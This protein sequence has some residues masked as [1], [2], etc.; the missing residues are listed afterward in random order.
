MR[1]CAKA[2]NAD[3]VA[4]PYGGAK[5]RTAKSKM[6]LNSF[7]TAHLRN[8]L[9]PL[10]ERR[11]WTGGASGSELLVESTSD[12][13]SGAGIVVESTTFPTRKASAKISK[14]FARSAL[15]CDFSNALLRIRMPWARCSARASRDAET[16]MMESR[17]E[18]PWRNLRMVSV[19]DR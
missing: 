12:E 9:H 10:I 15:D 3:N 16:L 7:T 1:T 5:S 11:K 4:T 2:F 13:P 6:D 14:S 19:I 8:S 17:V 18:S